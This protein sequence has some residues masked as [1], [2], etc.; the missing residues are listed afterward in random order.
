[1]VTYIPER[2]DV[3]WL[4]FSKTLGHEQRGRRPALVLS[5]KSYNRISGLA[6]VCPITSTIRGYLF[7]VDIQ[8]RKV[9]GSV[10]ADQVQSA[11]W[12]ERHARFI[13]TSPVS[14]LAEVTKR[15]G[16]LIGTRPTSF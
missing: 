2:G 7:A 6:I 1:M 16:I 4:A 5:P 11:A 12:R 3:V 14:T 9:N 10:L 8:G 15:L 13:E